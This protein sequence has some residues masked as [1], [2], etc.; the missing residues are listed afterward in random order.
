ML[1]TLA[2]FDWTGL[3]TGWGLRLAGALVI[4]LVGLWLVRWALR[5]LGGVF[6][7]A[8][9]DTMLAQFLINVGRAVLLLLVGVAALD[10]LGVPTTSLLAVLGATGLAIALALRDSLSNIAS[11]VMLITL[12]PFRTGDVVQI[13]G[14][15]GFV[16]QVRIFQTV[17][18]T[19]SNH[20]I[21]LPNS[22]ITASPIINFTA[23][24]QRRIEVPVG[25]SYNADVARAR[26]VLQAVAR[27]HEKVLEDPPCE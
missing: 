21:T 19:F 26:E 1:D 8:G 27:G 10:Q 15:E 4:A 24:G 14:Q 17:L 23:R 16:E 9:T 18:R 5:L 3:L 11:G 12:R 2:T 20:E 25:V 22:Q 6:R 13:A 7:R